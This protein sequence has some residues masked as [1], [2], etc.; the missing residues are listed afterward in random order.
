MPN[1]TVHWVND[2]MQI[3]DRLNERIHLMEDYLDTKPD[4]FDGIT[5]KRLLLGQAREQITWYQQSIDALDFVGAVA[6]RRALETGQ[7]FLEC[8]LLSRRKL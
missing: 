2:H 7:P 3:C 6:C 8:Y 4:N 5:V 1:H